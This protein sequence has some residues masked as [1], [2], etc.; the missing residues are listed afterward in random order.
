[1]K[2]LHVLNSPRAEGTVKLALDWLQEPDALQEVLVL[3]S[4]PADL[5]EKLRAAAGWY[6]E[7]GA[8]PGGPVKAVRIIL[9]VWR[10][11]RRRRPEVVLCWINGY[12]P[13]VLTGAWL[14]G[15]SRLITHA[16]N[17][18]TMTFS[19]RLQTRLS[20]L[21]AWLTQARMVC[22]SHYVAARYAQEMGPFASV[23]R[24]VHNCAPVAPIAEMAEHVRRERKERGLRLIMVATL[25][26]HKDH[27][28]LLRA[29][30]VVKQ[31]EPGVQL[32]LAGDGTLRAGLE[33]LCAR[34]GLQQTVSFLGSRRDVPVLLGRS[35]L[36]VFSTTAEE[37]LGT[38]LIEALAAGLPVVASDVP[39]CREVL[40]GGRWGTLVKAG[41]ADA[42]AAA[43][44]RSLQVRPRPEDTEAVRE[45]LSGFTPGK[46][47]AAYRSAV[48]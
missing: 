31:V 1:M 5:T 36:F 27:E 21:V 41:D 22:C 28:T 40:A 13:W 8:L 17:P 38:V 16:G 43:I 24:T 2:I 23:L 15:V 11:C 42:L 18:P 32:Q 25:E 12:A 37:G 46:M 19:G 3:N 4:S 47:M 7:G 9:L 20:G 34:L 10:T 30:V 44:I 29:M 45:Y 6:G 33:R 26:A 39:A 48:A 14:A 35:D